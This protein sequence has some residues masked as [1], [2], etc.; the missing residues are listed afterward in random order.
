MIT[1]FFVHG[2][3]V[4]R[5]AYNDLY[6]LL[7]TRMHKEF[8]DAVVRECYWGDACGAR[9]H[10]KGASIPSFTGSETRAF[11]G[12]TRAI[13][14]DERVL[15]LWARLYDDPF[16][17]LRVL[18]ARTVVTDTLSFQTG[19]AEAVVAR[20]H[21]WE[22][23]GEVALVAEEGGIA[24]EL[25]Q[26]RDRVLNSEPFAPAIGAAAGD[27]EELSATLARAMVATA[28]ADCVSRGRVPL[29][30]IDDQ[31]RD[32]L[33]AWISADLADRSRDT[34][35]RALSD[36]LTAP[37]TDVLSRAG[38]FY[39][40]RRRD[41]VF[42]AAAAVAGDIVLYQARGEA[43]HEFI[44]KQIDRAQRP[45]V[46]MAHSLGGIACVDM[47][48]TAA[49]NKTPLAVDLLVTAG[50]QAPFLY[51]IGALRSL[52]PDEVLPH[53]FPEWLN[54]YAPRDFLSYKAH[55]I[56]GEAIDAEIDIRQP[57]PRSH[58]AYWAHDGF[59]QALRA[60]FKVH[61]WI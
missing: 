3:G 24:H 48:A 39:V 15:H 36:M 61:Q 42:D 31:L 14:A 25:A 33:V 7:N 12:D 6:G 18:A 20:F 52:R 16:Y 2:T 53:G 1:V 49:R 38:T 22:P 45:V 27:P 57:F 58:S 55:P 43:F 11:E 51:E 10:H 5:Q 60:R 19:G 35:V 46:L 9:L 8:P 50:S 59:W 13:E 4:R 30:S 41:D 32:R 44:T 21:N 26:S 54:V 34:D 28:S 23:D 17:E 47:L 56:F 40:Q 29:A 37:I